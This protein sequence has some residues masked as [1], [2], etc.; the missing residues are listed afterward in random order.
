MIVS[1]VAV[2]AFT[3][4][5]LF[6]TLSRVSNVLHYA[7]RASTWGIAAAAFA[8]HGADVGG[9]VFRACLIYF[10]G[11]SF[12]CIDSFFSH[13]SGFS[14]SFSCCAFCFSSGLVVSAGSK[15]TH[16]NEEKCKD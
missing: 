16:G 10:H 7:N 14:S 5:H 8:M 3:S 6:T 15:E 4:L 13:I 2:L 11:F 9:S 12:R 1:F